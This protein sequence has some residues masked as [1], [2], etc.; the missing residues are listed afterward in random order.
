MTR[1]LLWFTSKLKKKCG[2]NPKILYVVD[3]I[4]NSNIKMVLLLFFIINHIQS[5]KGSHPLIFFFPFVLFS[6]LFCFLLFS[7]L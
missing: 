4:I 6:K 2:I 1:S 7:F 3:E 5:L